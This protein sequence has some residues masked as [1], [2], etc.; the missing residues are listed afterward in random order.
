MPGNNWMVFHEVYGSYYHTVAKILSAAVRGDLK[1]QDISKLVQTYAFAESWSSL[2]ESLCNGDWP[3]LD[4][5][6]ETELMYEPEMPLTTLQKQW[7][8]SM[9]NDPRIRLFLEEIPDWLDGVSPLFSPEDIVYFDRYSDADPY[10][11]PAYI[12]RFRTVLNALKKDR[13]L[14]VRFL[15]RIGIPVKRR[16][17][18]LHLEYSPRDDKF[19]LHCAGSS[20]H[21][22]PGTIQI[23]LNRIA[24]CRITE[25]EDIPVLMP[26]ERKKAQIILTDRRELLERF[27]R[28]FC[29][30]EKRTAPVEGSAEPMR[31]RVDLFYEPTDETELIIRLLSLG[32]DIEILSPDPLRTE[33]ARRVRRQK[34]LFAK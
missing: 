14:E 8:K 33:I 25:S 29:Y 30:L 21:V 13:W 17:K 5:D 10:E 16:V 11:D 34:E 22:W 7:L 28:L 6:L 31:Y 15:N 24:G 3:F 19:R 1:K 2:T 23:N 9:L 18:P 4:A 26:A 20:D 27:M 32:N 12:Q